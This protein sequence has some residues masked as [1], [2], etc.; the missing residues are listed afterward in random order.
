VE[1]LPTK[2]YVYYNLCPVV[3]IYSSIE[4]INEVVN[5]LSIIIFLFKYLPSPST[6][7]LTLN[8]HYNMIIVNNITGIKIIIHFRYLYIVPTDA[9]T[10]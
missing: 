6:C 7:L 4:Q 8:K 10:I 1:L 5:K 3:N 2:F 9:Q